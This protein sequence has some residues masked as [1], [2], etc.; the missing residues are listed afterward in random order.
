MEEKSIFF[1]CRPL[2]KKIGRF[3]MDLSMDIDIDFDKYLSDETMKRVSILVPYDKCV[4][5]KYDNE[6]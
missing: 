2:F 6:K 4:F 3:E 5:R 1:N